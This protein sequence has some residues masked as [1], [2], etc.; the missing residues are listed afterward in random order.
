MIPNKSRQIFRNLVYQEAADSIS[1]RHLKNSFAT[2]KI[3]HQDHV[4][5]VKVEFKTCF[6]YTSQK[7]FIEIMQILLKS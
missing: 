1:N 6:V 7:Q 5:C 3:D 4:C 2:M